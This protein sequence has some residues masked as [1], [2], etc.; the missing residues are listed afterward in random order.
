MLH[1]FLNKVKRVNQLFSSVA[2]AQ[3][4]TVILYIPE[5]NCQYIVPVAQ[6]RYQHHV[7]VANAE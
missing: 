2:I 5:N 7:N 1:I 4:H 3:S 6:L